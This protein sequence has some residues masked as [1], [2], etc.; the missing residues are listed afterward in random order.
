MCIHELQLLLFTQ[1]YECTLACH[2][3][4][5]YCASVCY[6]GSGS[7]NLC[8]GA[9][10]QDMRYHA[11]QPPT[12]ETKSS[13][14]CSLHGHSSDSGGCNVQKQMNSLLHPLC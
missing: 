2:V 8:V 7:G 9:S 13:S 12:S 11:P 4:S 3:L 10:L 1:K 14:A 6:V 5:V